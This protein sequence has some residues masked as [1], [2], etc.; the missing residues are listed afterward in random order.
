[1]TNFVRAHIGLDISEAILSEFVSKIMK[2]ID[3]NFPKIE[4]IV[5]S[6]L[7]HMLTELM[8]FLRIKEN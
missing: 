3:T 5:K 4:G 1:M 6:T 2:E 7:N 8:P